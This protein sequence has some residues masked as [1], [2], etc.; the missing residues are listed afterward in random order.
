MVAAGKGQNGTP[1]PDTPVV[2]LAWCF[3]S[4]NFEYLYGPYRWEPAPA[5]TPTPAN[6]ARTIY[7]EL[8]GR[9]PEPNIT[10]TPTPGT[11]SIIGIPVFITASNWQPALTITKDLAGTTVT[12]RATPELRYTPAEPDSTTITCTGPGTPYNPHGPDPARQAASPSV[13][14]HTYRHRTNAPG[15]PDTWHATATIHWTITWTATDGTHGTFPD[16][17]RTTA[18]PRPVHEIQ[19]LLTH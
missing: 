14:T 12:V 7:E 11:A 5:A 17:D 4:P 1:P 10:T 18:I 9:M 6:A 2:W 19:T 3:G 8:Q 16:V 13:C 15:R